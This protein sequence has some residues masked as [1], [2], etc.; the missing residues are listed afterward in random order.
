[1]VEIREIGDDVS[2]NNSA[3]LDLNADLHIAVNQGGVVCRPIWVDD[4]EL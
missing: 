4:D 1:M 3:E 2:F